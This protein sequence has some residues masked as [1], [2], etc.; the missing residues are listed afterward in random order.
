[1]HFH[2]EYHGQSHNAV[3]KRDAILQ[4]I[5]PSYDAI[6]KKIHGA[7]Q[8]IFSHRFQQL[9]GF[10]EDI[11]SPMLLNEYAVFTGVKNYTQLLRDTDPASNYL[12]ELPQLEDKNKAQTPIKNTAKDSAVTHILL[13]DTAYPLNHPNHYF[14][15]N[16]QLQESMAS[17]SFYSI[18]QTEQGLSIQVENNA[19]V[20]LNEKTLSQ[21]T[22]LHLG[23]NIKTAHVE[24][25]ATLIR[26][27]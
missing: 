25:S 16:H 2:I 4:K 15:G 18:Q 7:N 22:L 24:S 11:D 3:I 5:A 17:D 26:V 23:D 19:C 12:S 20:L 10:F 6:K 21:T 13:A 14:T 8:L 9:P 1:M 27:I